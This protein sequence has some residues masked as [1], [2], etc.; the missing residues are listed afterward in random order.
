MGVSVSH[1]TRG[2]KSF[3]ATN[4]PFV[5]CGSPPALSLSRVTGAAGGGASYST[6][7]ILDEVRPAT[8]PAGQRPG[9]QPWRLGLAGAFALRRTGLFGGRFEPRAS[10]RV[11]NYKR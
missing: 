9:G 7:R 1:E 11:I 8:S 6:C 2:G 10:L 5:R 4:T 3:P